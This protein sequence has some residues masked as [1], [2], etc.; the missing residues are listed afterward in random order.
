MDFGIY[1]MCTVIDRSDVKKSHFWTL[2]SFGQHTI[3]HMFPTL[4]H[5]ILPQLH[6]TFIETC[7]EFQMELREYSWWPLIVG[8][9]GQLQRDKPKT[10][11]EANYIRFSN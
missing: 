4:D 6:D 11:K 5:G 7:K 1:Q 9:F 2:V 10:L 8:Q 3:H